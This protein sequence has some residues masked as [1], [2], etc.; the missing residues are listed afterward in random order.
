MGY[1]MNMENMDNQLQQELEA[2]SPT[3]VFIPA[4]ENT[5]GTPGGSYMEGS[6]FVRK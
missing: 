2:T 5:L 6:H 1:I 4:A 3:L